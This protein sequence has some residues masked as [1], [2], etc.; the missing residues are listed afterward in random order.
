MKEAFD[1]KYGVT[2]AIP[3]AYCRFP[4][5]LLLK[6][7]IEGWSEIRLNILANGLQGICEALMSRKWSNTLIGL[8]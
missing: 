4:F 3:A 5:H 1:G 8:I 2:V 6:F 7:R